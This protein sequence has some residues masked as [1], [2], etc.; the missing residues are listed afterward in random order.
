[1]RRHADPSPLLCR[2]RLTGVIALKAQRGIAV[3]VV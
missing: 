1:M 3:S 2:W